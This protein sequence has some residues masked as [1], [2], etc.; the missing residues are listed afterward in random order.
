MEIIKIFKGGYINKEQVIGD[1][2]I[3]DKINTTKTNVIFDKTEHI[4]KTEL[5]KLEDE[6]V[7][8]LMKSKL[9]AD[10]T[11]AKTEKEKKTFEGQ[12]FTVNK[13]LNPSDTPEK[14]A[15]YKAD[16]KKLF[17]KTLLNKQDEIRKTKK[18]DYIKIFNS[19]VPFQP[20]SEGNLFSFLEKT[21]DKGF[22]IYDAKSAY[23]IYSKPGLPSFNREFYILESNFTLTKKNNFG[24]TKIS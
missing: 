22:I 20:N 18:E 7:F 19:I 9:E 12:L 3:I 15:G 8:K 14:K 10:I 23:E 11:S 4:F 5:E 16:L 1:A 13:Y 24:T 2:T 21:K 17:D 6:D